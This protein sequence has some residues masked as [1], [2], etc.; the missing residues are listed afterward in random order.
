MLIQIHTENFDGE[1]TSTTFR[2]EDIALIE[3]C[4][5]VCNE[6]PDYKIYLD[7]RKFPIRIDA[8]QWIDLTQALQPLVISIPSDG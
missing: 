7:S 5:I 2:S 1:T 8:M 6:L 3:Q 4:K